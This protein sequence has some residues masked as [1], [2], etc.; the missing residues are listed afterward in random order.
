MEQLLQVVLKIVQQL[1]KDLSNLDLL[2]QLSVVDQ[3]IAVLTQ[4]LSQLQTILSALTKA[5]VNV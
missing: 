2:K 5:G 3:L 4:L 1:L